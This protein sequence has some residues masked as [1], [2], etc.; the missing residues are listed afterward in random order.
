[1]AKRVPTKDRLVVGELVRYL[2]DDDTTI[3]RNIDEHIEQTI[4]KD[5]IYKVESVSQSGKTFF[6]SSKIFWLPILAKQVI[7]LEN[8]SREWSK[9][10]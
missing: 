4:K 1:M 7:P 10:Y 3:Y 6:I 2:G 8:T 5:G 9:V